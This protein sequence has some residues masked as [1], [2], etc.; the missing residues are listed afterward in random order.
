MEENESKINAK[1]KNVIKV[2]AIALLLMALFIANAFFPLKYAIT[3]LVSKSYKAEIG[4][5]FVRFLNVGYGDAAIIQLPDQKSLL[6]DC[7]DGTY[8]N[9]YKIIKELNRC[10]I[11]KIDYAICTNIKTEHCGGFS[12]IIKNKGVGT[13]FC[14]YLPSGIVCQSVTE[15]QIQA[16]K[17]GATVKINEYGAGEIGENYFFTILS[18]SSPN[19][20]LSEYEVLRKNG[21]DKNI[22]DA[23]A[24]VWLNIF[25]TDI[26]FMSD[27]SYDV[28]EKITDEFELLDTEYR[29]DKEHAIDLRTCKIL[30]VSD[31]GHKRGSNTYFYSVLKPENAVISVGEN[32]REDCPSA[33]VIADLCETA[34]AYATQN[35]GNVAFKITAEGYM[36]V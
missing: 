14:P 27:V 26:L 12:E 35:Y 36:Q 23:S 28:L 25:D 24:V 3:Y 6:I 32:S 10:G 33:E 16:Q 21:T 19:N 11:Q 20:D 9:N 1:T 30:K 31:H 34:T 8:A 18:P 15:S 5:A 7:G 29:P 2:S 22:C 4:E 13:L 17:C